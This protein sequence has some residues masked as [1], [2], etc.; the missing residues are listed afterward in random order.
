[1]KKLSVFKTMLVCAGVAATSIFAAGCGPGGPLPPPPPSPN[2]INVNLLYPTPEGAEMSFTYDEVTVANAPKASTMAMPQL[3]VLV[4]HGT[5]VHPS[6]FNIPAKDNLGNDYQLKFSEWI[7]SNPQQIRLYRFN[8]IDFPVSF[9]GI[10]LSLDV[11]AKLGSPIELFNVDDQPGDQRVITTS[12]ARV[13]LA[14][15]ISSDVTY[16]GSVSFISKSEWPEDPAVTDGLAT[17][18]RDIHH[19]SYDITVDLADLKAQ[20]ENNANETIRQI[21]TFIPPTLNVRSD[22]FLVPGV[23]MIRKNIQIN[24]STIVIPPINLGN[25]GY[26]DNDAD[27]DH[28]LD[29]ADLADDDINTH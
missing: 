15:L 17:V 20:Y 28:W 21:A 18:P 8:I 9:E 6:V 11:S 19:L 3:G 2:V 27:N 25:Y 22:M 29:P 24:A 7:H 1:M 26:S 13:T 14:G 23:G 10:N 16:T 4:G 5:A 12:G